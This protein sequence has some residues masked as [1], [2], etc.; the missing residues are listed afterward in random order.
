MLSKVVV[1]QPNRQDAHHSTA[2]TRSAALANDDRVHR[3]EPATTDPAAP[4]PARH[5]QPGPPP[6]GAR[7]AAPP[8]RKVDAVGLQPRLA[9]H[10]A[11]PARR[12][13]VVRLHPVPLPPVPGL[14]ARPP[15]RAPGLRGAALGAAAR[16]PAA[17][18]GHDPAHPRHGVAPGPARAGDPDV[19]LWRDHLRRAGDPVHTHG[20]DP[21]CADQRGVPW[22]RGPILS[23]GRGGGRGAGRRRIP[24]AA[25]ET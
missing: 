18:L 6:P 10:D 21:G 5:R 9:H 25:A 2:P 14:R 3:L 22:L 23:G 1:N 15:R 24:Q 16:Q 4:P 17:A 19:E 20:E 12:G 11:R 7:D 8:V 13:R